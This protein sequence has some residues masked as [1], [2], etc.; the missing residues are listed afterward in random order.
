MSTPTNGVQVIQRA[1]A[2]LGALADGPLGVTDVAVR[3]H[4][5]KSTAARLLAALAAEGA[6]EQVPGESRYRL[7]PHLVALASGLEDAR[8]LVATSRPT[9]VALAGELGEAASPSVRDGW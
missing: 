5:P 3:S 9:L 7:G 4:I 6:V 1:F 8:G 2:V